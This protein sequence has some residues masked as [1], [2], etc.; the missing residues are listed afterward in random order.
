M[1]HLASLVPLTFI[2]L[3]PRLYT[4]LSLLFIQTLEPLVYYYSS[5]WFMKI[6]ISS[7]SQRCDFAASRAQ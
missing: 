3:L 7:S 6:N 5:E 4:S 1:L 2:T